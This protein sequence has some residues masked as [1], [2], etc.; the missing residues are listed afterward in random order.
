MNKNFEISKLRI[1]GLL[2]WRDLVCFLR[3]YK[4]HFFNSLIWTLTTLGVTIYLLP[5]FGLTEAFGTFTLVGCVASIGF[6]GAALEA[7]L[8]IFDI[9]GNNHISY[10]LTLPI[11]RRLVLLQR[12]LFSTIRVML[13]SI[14]ILPIGK[15]V[16]WHRIDLSQIIIWK[17]IIIF[18]AANFMFGCMGLWFTN[19]VKSADKIENV[20]IRVFFPLWFLGG[21][22][23]SWQAML[24]TLPFFAYIALLNPVLYAMEGYRAT[25]IGQ[26]GFINFWIC[27]V[28][29]IVF[30]IILALR[31]MSLIKK[32]LDCV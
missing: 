14:V 21:Y 12:I 11:G 15:I 5:K 10:D 16:F 1:F 27:V 30:A 31:G 18:F 25:V 20:W 24:E 3:S 8:F 26:S 9:E 13:L 22:Q 19:F 17:F 7:I 2:L 6:F 28:M 29:M 23:F 4:D 32:R